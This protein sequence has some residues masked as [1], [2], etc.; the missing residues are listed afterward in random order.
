MNEKKDLQ[1]LDIAESP[2]GAAQKNEVKGSETRDKKWIIVAAA[3]LAIF[4][5]ST[6][7]SLAFF[8]RSNDNENPKDIPA[9]NNS[10]KK[11]DM[12]S[13]N[14]RLIDGVFVDDDNKV[15]PPIL[16]AMIDNHP[17]ARP[18][19]GISKANLVIEAEAEGGVTRFMAIFSNSEEI[20][21]IGSIRSARAYFVDWAQEYGALYAHCGGSPEALVKIEQDGVSDLNEFYN[22]PYYWRGKEKRAPH[23]VYT[24]S[25]KISS[26]L[27]DN[28]VEEGKF[29]PWQF[30][31]DLEKDKRPVKQQIKISFPLPGYSV[32][33]NY[34]KENN[35]Y[36]RKM[37]NDFHKDGM[38]DIISV[39]NVVI[40]Y[41]SAR[42]VDEKLRL[43][44]DIIGHGNAQICL[45]GTCQKGEWR[46]KDS[47]SRTRFYADNG[48]EFEFNAGQTWVEV[49]RP[50]REVFVAS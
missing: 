22:A 32:E 34:D 23:N 33:W 39:K 37:G 12:G 31:E 26:Y 4:V 30:K 29:E 11:E 9:E 3:T 18:S 40:Q 28:G 10:D 45:D 14:R 21:K 25:E 44:M 7:V 5:V 24:S 36:V 27:D 6:G 16:A 42:E 19:F 20:E 41:A 8:W 50:E 35:I 38:G 2:I 46:K 47:K 48:K 43:D 49:V 17:D 15:N 1:G 13:K